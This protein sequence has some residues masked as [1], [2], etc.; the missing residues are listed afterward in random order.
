MER[1]SLAS[2]PLKED[3]APDPNWVKRLLHMSLEANGGVHGRDEDTD[4]LENVSFKD[5]LYKDQKSDQET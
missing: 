5:L 1:P 4:L 2:G 3:V